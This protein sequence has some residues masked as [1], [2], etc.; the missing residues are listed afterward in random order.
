MSD[1]DRVARWRQR[2]RDEG[3]EPVTLW[4]SHEE[5]QR[6]EDLAHTGRCSTSEIASQALAHF[7][8]ERPEGTGNATDTEQLRDRVRAMVLTFLDKELPGRLRAFVQTLGR[9]MAPATGTQTTGN[10]SVAPDGAPPVIPRGHPTAQGPPRKGGRPRSALGARILAMLAEHPEGLSAEE[11]RVYV[12]ADRPIGDTLAGMKKRG[13]I[14]MHGQG[15]Q[16]RY[17]LVHSPE[18]PGTTG[19][20]CA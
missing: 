20:R 15:K 5:K 18:N 12:Q 13:D 7:Q 19:E 17:V 4:L 9:T 10:V 3:K 1:K 8:P 14:L 2:M 16:A 11:L 6:L